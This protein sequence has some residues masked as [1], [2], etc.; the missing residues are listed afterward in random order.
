MLPVENLNHFQPMQ[1]LEAKLVGIYCLMRVLLNM[2][3][4]RL[5]GLRAEGNLHLILGVPMLT[6][7][8]TKLLS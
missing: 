7:I 1:E 4:D 8:P 5:N 2:R 3:L 6:Q